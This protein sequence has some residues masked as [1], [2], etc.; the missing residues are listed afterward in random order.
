VQDF[1][2]NFYRV[3]DFIEES[4]QLVAGAPPLKRGDPQGHSDRV[5]TAAKVIVT[6]TVPSLGD[7]KA[8]A[9]QVPRSGPHPGGRDRLEASR[10]HP[11]QD[12][13]S[14]PKVLDE[15]ETQ[16]NKHLDPGH[17]A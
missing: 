8:P 13:R 5:F 4:A 14:K 10:R 16:I 17:T 7:G 2:R 12:Y 15:R 3:I 6:N 9:L 11:G 1:G